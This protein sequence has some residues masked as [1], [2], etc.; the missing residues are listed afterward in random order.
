[1]LEQLSES[2][3]KKDRQIKD[4]CMCSAPTCVVFWP[5]WKLLIAKEEEEEEKNVHHMQIKHLVK[6]S[7]GQ[8]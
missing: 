5:T 3:N 2:F 8:V 7:I 1:M 6:S 4:I